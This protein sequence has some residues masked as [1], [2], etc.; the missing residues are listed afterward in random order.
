MCSYHISITPS[1]PRNPYALR[2]FTFEVLLVP[3][4]NAKN[5]S[6]EYLICQKCSSTY[7][8]KAKYNRKTCHHSSQSRQ[9]CFMRSHY[10]T[11]QG[12][13]KYEDSEGCLQDQYLTYSLEALL[14]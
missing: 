10:T 6:E 7:I 5:G 12:F 13:L 11:I 8:K 14:S 4:G 2:E 3:N 1:T 9:K